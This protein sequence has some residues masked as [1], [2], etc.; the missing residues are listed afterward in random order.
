[1]PGLIPIATGFAG[2]IAIAVAGYTAYWHIAAGEIEDRIDSWADA[3]RE[4]G[5]DVRYAE[6]QVNGF[7]MRF[8]VSL[9]APALDASADG[10]SFEADS[11]AASL[12]PWDFG[13]ITLLPGRLSTVRMLNGEQ[14]DEFGLGIGG[15]T[16]RLEL[17]GDT[18]SG[19][20]VDLNDI[21]VKTAWVDGP[22]EIVR[23][24]ID[25]TSPQ[26]GSAASLDTEVLHTAIAM[27]G[28]RLP[29]GF[30]AEMG[31]QIEYLEMD[32]SLFG[33]L[34]AA[35][36]TGTAAA[37]WRDA[38]GVLEIND[39]RVRWGPLGIASNGTVTLDGAMRP[40]AA[41]TADIIG[42]GDIID[43]LIMSNAIP[44]GDAFLAKVAFNMLAEE[45]EGGGPKT[46]RNVPVTAQGGALSVGPVAVAQIPPLEF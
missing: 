28:I 27:H 5:R 8:D 46:L 15:G 13:E 25:G 39:F 16:A 10:W 41:L 11:F 9:D 45:P 33:P 1:M 30:G 24:R 20:L 42:Y 37:A 18:I 35:A 12:K 38:G 26:A 36:D 31:E 34:P 23:L 19:L 17:D 40:L 43:A 29:D 7:P 14:W 21:A 6:P 4:A 44:L 2:G 22:A 32:A 3:Q